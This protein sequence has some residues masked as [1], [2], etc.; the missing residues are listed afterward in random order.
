MPLVTAT[1]DTRELAAVVHTLEAKGR[2]LDR[3]MPQIAEI[4]VAAVDDV[5]EAEGP[6]WDD[7]A[8]STKRQRRGSTYTILQDTGK[9]A[10]STMG[11][12]GAN[13]AEAR[14]HDA[15][16]R[17]HASGTSKMPQRNPFDLGPFEDEALDEIAELLLQEVTL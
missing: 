14:A 7:L 2:Q 12:A 16:A 4:L 3:L 13:W 1:I 5:Y 15:K 6:D 8:Q 10:G 9:M 11:H 17:Y